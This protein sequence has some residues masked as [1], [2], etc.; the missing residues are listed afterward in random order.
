MKWN[1]FYNAIS[2]TFI[3]ASKDDLKNCT[4]SPPALEKFIWNSILDVPVFV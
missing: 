4:T 2:V 3:Q 1:E